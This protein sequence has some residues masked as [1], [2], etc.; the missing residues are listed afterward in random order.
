M[1]CIFTVLKLNL[2]SWDDLWEI[3]CYAYLR[4]LSSICLPVMTSGR[5]DSVY[6]SIRLIEYM[7]FYV[8]VSIR[9]IEYMC[10]YVYVSIRL[11]EYTCFYVYVSIRL[12]EYT[13]FYVHVSIRLIEINIPYP[14]SQPTSQPTSHQ[15]A[16]QLWRVGQ[17]IICIFT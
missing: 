6:V 8:H 1:L 13:C 16:S 5:A 9:L 17:Q 3:I 4:C 15:P 2:L 12:I 11:I 10:F 7:C 14:A